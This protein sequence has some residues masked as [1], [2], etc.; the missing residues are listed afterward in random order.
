MKHKKKCRFFNYYSIYERNMQNFM[1]KNVKDFCC[2]NYIIYLC[3]QIYEK[4][5]RMMLNSD[6]NYHLEQG[7]VIFCV[8]IP[9]CIEE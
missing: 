2:L 4:D 9:F 3:P 5:S 6:S 7:F 8:H 1:I